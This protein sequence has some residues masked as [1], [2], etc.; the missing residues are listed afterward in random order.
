MML[1]SF[2]RR[3]IVPEMALATE[4]Q[5]RNAGLS[6]QDERFA[7]VLLPEED[8]VAGLSARLAAALGL[9]E[10]FV[11]A[12][13]IAARFR[14]AG[15]FLAEQRGVHPDKTAL[16][17]PLPSPARIEIEAELA[18]DYLFSEHDQTLRM[19]REV[20][21]STRERWDG[22]GFPEGLAGAQIPGAARIVSICLAYH[23]LTQE[24][25]YGTHWGEA[26]ALSFLVSQ[27]CKRFDPQMVIVFHK[28][29]RGLLQ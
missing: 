27:A 28:L 24:T 15:R 20:A 18:G 1:D 26:D 3:Y 9:G 13:P 25:R 2:F 7:G 10:A 11:A 4:Q 19:A 29:R 5:S 22:F 6:W 21:V 14:D 17:L 23:A 16:E 8:P 12:I